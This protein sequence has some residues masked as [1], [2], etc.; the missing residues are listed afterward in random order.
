MN[1]E[2]GIVKSLQETVVDTID[3]SSLKARAKTE[4]Q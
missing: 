1:T 3:T 4:R 2:D